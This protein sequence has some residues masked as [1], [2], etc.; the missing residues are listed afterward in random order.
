MVQLMVSVVI[1]VVLCIV[2]LTFVVLVIIMVVL[3]M[4]VSA[5]EV[6]SGI[7]V[8]HVVRLAV[9]RQSLELNIVM[10]YTVEHRITIVLNHFC[11]HDF[12][13]HS[14]LLVLMHT[15]ENRDDGITVHHLHPPPPSLSTGRDSSEL[16]QTRVFFAYSCSPVAAL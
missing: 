10:L 7:G 11:L 4:M 5:F 12:F 8:G 9:K 16:W 14:L 1:R 15:V 2:V 3:F 6:D 13:E